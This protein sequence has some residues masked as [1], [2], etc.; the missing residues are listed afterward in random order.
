[1]LEYKKELKADLASRIPYGVMVQAKGWDKPI[2]IRELDLNRVFAKSTEFPK[3]YLRPLSSMTEEEK[4]EYDGFTQYF[5]ANNLPNY[6][7]YFVEDD[8]VGDFIDWLNAHHLDYRELI[9]LGEA[10]EA[11][12]DMYNF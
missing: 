8:M 6:H 1:M 5:E 2:D 11:P 9:R 10:L 7:G 3:P 12:K 4:K